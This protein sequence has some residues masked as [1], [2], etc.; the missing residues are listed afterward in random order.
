MF[1]EYF[2]LYT[3]RGNNVIMSST[4]G[5]TSRR[6]EIARA[7]TE[8][9]ATGGARAVTHSAIDQRL[10]LPK[11]S[12]S[13]YFRTRSA[14]ISAGIDAMRRNSRSS[15]STLVSLPDT[16]LAEVARDYVLHLT[17]KRAVEIRARLALAAEVEP[18]SL[19]SLFFN[20][21]SAREA[22]ASL[23]AEDPETISTGFIDLLEGILL[24][25]ALLPSGAEGDLTPDP[26]EILAIIKTY[27]AGDENARVQN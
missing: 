8:L 13:Y 7:V 10:E 4:T 12:T 26:D 2:A 14:L 21:D 19:S 1:L 25:C 17:T 3:Y 18:D 24:R 5:N 20:R 22:F 27:L 9:A 23:G 11:G 16:S 15:F 6:D